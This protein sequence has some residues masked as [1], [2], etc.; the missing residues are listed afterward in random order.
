MATKS[1]GGGGQT[2]EDW[3][4]D[5]PVPVRSQKRKKNPPKPAPKGK[6]K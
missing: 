5:H 4:K 2:Q 1:G 6:K 3:Y